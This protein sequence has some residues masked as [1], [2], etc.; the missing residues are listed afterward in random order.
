LRNL[1]R[2]ELLLDDCDA[3]SESPMESRNRVVFIR[4]GLPRPETQIE[5]RDP[6]TG[7]FVGRLDMGWR[8]FKTAAEFDGAFHQFRSQ[9]DDLRRAAIS[10]LGWKVFVFTA[11]DVYGRP[12]EMVAEVAAALRQRRS[13]GWVRRSTEGEERRTQRM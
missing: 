5:V 6:V 10:A 13:G 9:A 11:D 8:E 4:G 2:G 7:R 12:A 1:R 3:G